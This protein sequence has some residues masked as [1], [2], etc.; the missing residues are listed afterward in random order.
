MKLTNNQMETL[1]WKYKAEGIAKNLSLQAFCSI[2]DVPY[3]QFEKFLKLRKDLSEVHKVNIT[4]LPTDTVTESKPEEMP[5]NANTP[6]SREVK[7][8][9]R[10]KE[11]NDNSMTPE[12]EPVESGA[13]TRIM[14]NIRM[15]N[16]MHVFRKN[17]SYRELRSLVEKL[18][19]LC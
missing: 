5:V 15:S 14:I 7:V 4:G 9:F 10:K 16:G 6:A 17:M 19:V 3:N 1:W 13:P 12:A 2:H 18:E 11:D 8:S